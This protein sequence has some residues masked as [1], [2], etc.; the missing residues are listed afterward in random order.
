MVVRINNGVSF[1]PYREM[2]RRDPTG[3]QHLRLFGEM[4]VVNY[5][6][7][8]TAMR[9]EEGPESMWDQHATTRVTPTV[10]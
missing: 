2:W 7:T 8:S 1:L 4:G 3:F 10:F 6:S 5:G 9:I